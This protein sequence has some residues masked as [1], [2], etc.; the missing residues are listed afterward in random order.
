MFQVGLEQLNLSGIESSQSE[1][2]HETTELKYFEQLDAST[3]HLNQLNDHN[4]FLFSKFIEPQMLCR[5]QHPQK[6]EMM[7]LICSVKCYKIF[8]QNLAAILIL[9]IK[10]ESFL[11]QITR[12]Q[13][14]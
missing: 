13:R 8:L 1:P 3:P 5:L 6:A 14:T 12:L 11:L 9:S 4:Y 2:S 7:I 10:K